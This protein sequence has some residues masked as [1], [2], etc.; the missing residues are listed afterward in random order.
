MFSFTDDELITRVV[1]A[2]T[3]AWSTGSPSFAHRLNLTTTSSKNDEDR[4]LDGAIA[5]VLSVGWTLHSA[6]P[7]IQ[8]IGPNHEMVLLVF[9]RPQT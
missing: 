5:G 7:Y 1:D 3:E 8:T 6:A 9:V 2:A 4:I